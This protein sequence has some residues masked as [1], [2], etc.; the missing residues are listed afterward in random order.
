PFAARALDARTG[1]PLG[2]VGQGSRLFVRSGEH[3]GRIRVDWG[4]RQDQQCAID[5]SVPAEQ[6]AGTGYVTLT[7]VCRS[8][9]SLPPRAGRP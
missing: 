9:A 5:Y 7:R 4:P 6:R 2:A 8:P 3:D 1:A